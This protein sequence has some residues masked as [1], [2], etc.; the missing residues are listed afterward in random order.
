MKTPAL[1]F[2]NKDISGACKSGLYL[3][4][5]A[6]AF[7]LTGAPAGSRGP[8]RPAAE[9]TRPGEPAAPRTSADRTGS[10]TTSEGLTLRLTTDLGSIK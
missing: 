1:Y 7:L 4:L 2:S 3:L 5:C 9:L 6:A 8:A 10:L